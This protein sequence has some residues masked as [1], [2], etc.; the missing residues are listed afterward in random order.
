MKDLLRKYKADF[1]KENIQQ[2]VA[3]IANNSHQYA[4]NETFKKLFSLIDLT[5]LN[6][7]DNST[8]I[9][10]IC[11]KVNAFKKHYSDIP[12]VAA[13]C[14]YPNMVSTVKQNL[15][16]EEVEIASVGG[17]FP[18]SQTFAEIKVEECKMAITAGAS[19]VDIVLSVGTFFEGNYDTCFNEIKN[20]KSAIGN[21]H[22]KVILESGALRSP[23]EIWEAS[24]L[25]ME[26]GADFIK[27]STGKQSP[28]ATTDAVYIMTKAIR[29]F[30]EATGKKIGIKPAGGIATPEDALAYF[31]LVQENLGEAW[32]T[33]ELF[34]IGASRLANNL[35]SEIYQEQI[36]YF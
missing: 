15:S 8:R 35:L 16:V 21:N 25:A 31:A 33:P 13:I 19:E 5:S 1:L 2:K 29:A 26:A 6:T 30:Y 27:T 11:E 14:V 24:L 32:L 4:T 3:V 18:S 23:Q 22:L 12:N 7:E 28:A 9:K 17:G 20:I 10:A 34:R 36:S